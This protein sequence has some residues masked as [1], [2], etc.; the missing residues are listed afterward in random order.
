[1]SEVEPRGSS[2]SVV[3]VVRDDDGSSP[4]S[5]SPSAKMIKMEER[6]EA[7]SPSPELY[8]ALPFNQSIYLG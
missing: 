8:V 5:T 3:E 7:P 6:V 2:S 1:M 4:L